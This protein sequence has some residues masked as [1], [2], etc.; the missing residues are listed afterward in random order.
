M[1]IQT[2]NSD[3]AELVNFTELSETDACFVL[4]MRNHPEIKKWMYNQ[5]EI[6][7]AQHSNFI[8]ML[9]TNSTKNYFLVKQS[10]LIIGTINFTK[11]DRVKKTADFGLY[12]NPY[13]VK[14]GAG[15]ILEKV[16]VCYAK[17]NLKLSVLNLEV[18]EK[19][20]R[21]INFYNKNGFKLTGRR[22][23]NDQVVLCMQKLLIK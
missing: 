14:S 11:I 8:E 12:T 6:T 22:A 3:V 13:N 10:D 4:K 20:E 9:K 17:N 15:R 16:A 2:Q 7:E 23:I 19:N 21:A 1:N 5:E 18:F